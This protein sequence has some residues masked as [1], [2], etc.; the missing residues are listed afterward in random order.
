MVF[1][2]FN[3]FHHLTALENVMLAQR[4]VRKRSK[5]EADRDRA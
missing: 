5:S 2:Q 1:Q 3:L 4:L